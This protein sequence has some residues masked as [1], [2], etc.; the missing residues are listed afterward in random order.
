MAF[1]PGL[2]T[3]LGRIMLEADLRSENPRRALQMRI[4]SI[5]FE[6][7]QAPMLA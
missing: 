2:G 4:A 7:K 5:S 3:D 6:S 1:A